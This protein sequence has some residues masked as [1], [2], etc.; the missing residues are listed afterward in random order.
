MRCAL[1]RPSP[2]QSDGWPLAKSRRGRSGR[3]TMLRAPAVSVAAGTGSTGRAPPAVRTAARV[4]AAASL[5][6]RVVRVLIGDLRVGAGRCAARA[7]APRRLP[8]PGSSCRAPRRRRSWPVSAHRPRR[9]GSRPAS[10]RRVRSVWSWTTSLGSGAVP[11]RAFGRRSVRPPSSS[12]LTRAVPRAGRNVA[13]GQNP[14]SEDSP[15]AAPGR[16]RRPPVNRRCR[17]GRSGNG[18]PTANDAVVPRVGWGPRRGGNR[19]WRTTRPV[20]RRSRHLRGRRQPGTFG[21]ASPE[22]GDEQDAGRA[23]G[24]VVGGEVGAGGGAVGEERRGR[25]WRGAGPA[26]RVVRRGS[27]TRRRRSR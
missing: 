13:H 20:P 27:A 19:G 6:V 3:S 7:T 18:L 4:A 9:S 8:I 12:T 21:R 2:R 22:V 14:S 23:I 5:R 25:R 24:E 26:R 10:P 15:G 1:V 16:R 11:C 17:R